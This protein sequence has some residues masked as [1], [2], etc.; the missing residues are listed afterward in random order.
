MDV[1]GDGNGN[2]LASH[3]LLTGFARAIAFFIVAVFPQLHGVF[4]VV[5]AILDGVFAKRV[6]FDVKVFSLS[7]VDR[8]L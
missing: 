1:K 7:S 2:V 5:A 6:G 3:P 4:R 8:S